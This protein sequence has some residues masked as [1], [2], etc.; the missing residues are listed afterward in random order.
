M[1]RSCSTE[2]GVAADHV[3]VYRWVQRFTPLL[4]DAA[5]PLRHV[6]EG[7]WFDDETYSPLFAS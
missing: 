6:T 5:R 2:R 4:V 3:S 1:S 7:R